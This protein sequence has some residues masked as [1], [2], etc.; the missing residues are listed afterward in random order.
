MTSFLK[1]YI[2]IATTLLFVIMACST[3]AF[4]EFKNSSERLR[5]QSFTEAFISYSIGAIIYS[6]TWIIS[7]PL[8]MILLM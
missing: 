4:N 6:Y 3:K 5:N 2:E 7:V 1:I 8:T